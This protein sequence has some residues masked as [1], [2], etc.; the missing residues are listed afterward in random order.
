MRQ[1]LTYGDVLIVPNYSNIRSRKD[2]DVTSNYLG[3]NRLPLISAPMD[4]VTGFKMAE[5]LSRLNAYGVVSRFREEEDVPTYRADD[6]AIAV[7]LNDFDKSF[8]W[9]KENKPH[10]I[11]IDVA[12]GDH[13][14]VVHAI[15]MYK[16]MFEFGE[17]KPYVIAGNVATK[18]GFWRLEAAGA[19]AVRVG[20]G[21][22][23]ACTTRETTGIG[24]PQLTAILDIR[25]RAN[26][27]TAIIAD[28]GIQ[29][30]GDIVKALAAGADAVML[31]KMFAGHDESPGKILTEIRTVPVP[32][33][34]KPYGYIFKEVPAYKPYR[35]QSVLGTNGARNA[36]EGVEGY[37]DYKG[38][39]DKTVEQLVNYIQ[40]GMS[41]VGA[42]NIYELRDRAEFIQISPAT[43]AENET[44]I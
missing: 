25:K 27:T 3:K 17:Y 26:S 38:P 16:S 7:G 12:H 29:Y 1:G 44:R 34:S 20:I 36:P 11:C 31:G 21:P 24:V 42:R 40:S 10:A 41:Y 30:P 28:G 15:R 13:D 22:G 18:E 37:V 14:R 5:T 4:Y 9:I 39:V 8:A 6:Y 43:L 2:I 35:G 32:D 19:D 33:G 23:S